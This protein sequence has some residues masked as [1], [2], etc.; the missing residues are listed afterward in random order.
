MYLA[1]TSARSLIRV[2]GLR[3][4]LA[5]LASRSNSTQSTAPLHPPISESSKPSPTTT[6]ESNLLSP[7]HPTTSL[8]LPIDPLPSPLPEIQPVIVP[9]ETLVKLH[10]LS[11]LNPPPEGSKE[12]AQLVSELSELVGL[13]ELV[14]AVPLPEGDL[15]SLLSEGLGEVVVDGSHE[16]APGLEVEEGAEEE[17]RSRE[18][19]GYATRRVGD[20]YAS[21]LET[22]RE[23]DT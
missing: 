8:G 18:L 16:D 4:A 10:R 9:R 6:N 22:K 15:S 19:L 7:S 13:M 17:V 21:R 5:H 3:I 23:N 20:Y 14:K 1:T 2:S 11:A 12:E